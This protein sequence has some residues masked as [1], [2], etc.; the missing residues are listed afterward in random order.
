MMESEAERA[1]GLWQVIP[2]TLSKETCG[3]GGREGGG[4]GERERERENFNNLS[5][6][7][8]SNHILSRY[9]YW[10]ITQ[11]STGHLKHCICISVHIRI[12]QTVSYR[13]LTHSLV[14]SRS[15]LHFASMISESHIK[16]GC[17]VAA[18]QVVMPTATHVGTYSQHH[19]SVTVLLDQ[20]FSS[21]MLQHIQ[22]SWPTDVT[23]SVKH[24]D[25]NREGR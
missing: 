7:N 3:M 11:L 17:A 24:W 1:L 9:W 21:L 16:L 22:T 15:K 14:G 4:E 2:S 10:E 25:T 23:S 5:L 6:I 18:S 20:G 19:P 13:S 8:T 12:S